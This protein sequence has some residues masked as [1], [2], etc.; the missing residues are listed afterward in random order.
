MIRRFVMKRGP[1]P[2]DLG[3]RKFGRLIVICEAEQ[4]W[5][6]RHWRC[7]CECGRE[8][9][10]AGTELKRGRTRSCRCAGKKHGECIDPRKTREY[11][12]WRNMKSRCSNPKATGYDYYG[13]NGIT[14]CPEW[15]NSFVQFLSDMRRVPTRFHSIDRIDP[16]DGY[17][18]RNCRWA[19]P[20]E[21]AGN[22]GSSTSLRIRITQ[23][24]RA[25]PRGNCSP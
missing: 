1:K 15:R 17:E 23:G 5:G 20:V 13:G 4:K 7:R 2:E 10:A 21:Q 25:S 14:V 19:T 3:G 12:I 18:P 16:T 8:C 9:V 6:H 24:L 11:R 22:K